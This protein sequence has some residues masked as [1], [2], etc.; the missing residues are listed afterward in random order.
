MVMTIY[1]HWQQFDWLKLNRKKL[2]VTIGES[3]TWGDSLGLTQHNIYDDKEFRLQNVYGKQ[4]ADK[5]DAD[6]L[7][8]AKPGESNLWI[9]RHFKLFADSI[10]QFVYD[11]IFVVLT[12]TEVGREFE[13]DLDGDRDYM[14]DLKNI[15]CLTKF[16]QTLSIYVSNEILAVDQD[17]IKLLIATNFVDSNYPAELNVLKKS[18]VDIIAEQLQVPV[19][20]PC[21]VV[22]SWVFDRFHQILNFSQN[23]KKDKFLTDMLAHLAI[24]K[25]VT[26]FLLHSRFNYKKASKHPTPEA[27]KFWADYL[28]KSF[29]SDHA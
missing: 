18:W 24:A 26:D 21:Y 5:L 3:W 7:N 10:D 8:I 20:K 14:T 11:E 25:Q 9:A 17:K 16:L 27:H 13:G 2:L 15:S 1:D 29:V 22:G 4:L 23:Y 28:Y 6:F 19:A 12:L